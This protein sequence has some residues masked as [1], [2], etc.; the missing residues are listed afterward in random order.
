MTEGDFFT[1]S[2]VGYWQELTL[3]VGTCARIREI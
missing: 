2:T 3:D 1:E